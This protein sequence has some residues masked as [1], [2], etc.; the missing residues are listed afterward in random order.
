MWT[1]VENWN[2]EI[3]VVSESAS[4]GLRQYIEW[5]LADP[6]IAHNFVKFTLIFLQVPTITAL[7]G[8]DSLGDVSKTNG[9]SKKSELSPLDL[10]CT[11]NGEGYGFYENVDFLVK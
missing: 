7:A 6:W 9:S 1:L 2:L 11:T 5:D 10:S 4:D 8:D 3:W